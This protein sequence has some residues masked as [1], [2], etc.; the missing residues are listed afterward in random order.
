MLSFICWWAYSVPTPINHTYSPGRKSKPLKLKTCLVA[1]SD[2]SYCLD[3]LTGIFEACWSCR[4]F[5]ISVLCALCPS[6]WRRRFLFFLFFFLINLILTFFISPPLLLLWVCYYKVKCAKLAVND[7]TATL[8][9]GGGG[10]RG[11]TALVF[12][13]ISRRSSLNLH[14]NG[15]WSCI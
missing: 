5:C 7:W 11:G 9:V 13:G 15:C 10:F 12:S 1:V 4:G 2:L 14:V 3:P 8:E 6:V